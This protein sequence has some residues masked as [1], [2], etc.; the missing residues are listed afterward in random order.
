MHSK[1]Y[2]I[3]M[4]G[5]GGQGIRI[6]GIV[7]GTAA[8]IEGKYAS[9][10]PSYGVETRG[11][12]S[13][14]DVII[15]DNRIVY[16]RATSIDILV[17]MASGFSEYINKVKNGGSIILDEDLVK[18]KIERSDVTVKR[19]AITSIA[20]RLGKRGMVNMVMLGRLISITRILSEDSIIKSINVVLPEHLRKDNIEAFKVGMV[21]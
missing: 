6:A 10:W 20:D 13:I 18:E 2:S 1:E 7:L 3:K 16:P 4:A 19:V 14:S 21:W 5:V 15:S 12:P 11:G 8:T 9:H 17:L